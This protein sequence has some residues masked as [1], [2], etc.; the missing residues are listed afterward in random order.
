MYVC[1]SAGKKCSF[2]RKIWHALLSR[3]TRFEIRLFALLPMT[4]YLNST[5]VYFQD[6]IYW[7]FI[8]KHPYQDSLVKLVVDKG[9]NSDFAFLKGRIHCE[10]FLSDNFM[11][12]SFRVI[13]WN[14]KYFH[15]ILLLK[16]PT[17]IAYVQ[18]QPPEV[19][20][21]KRCS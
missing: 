20:C 3:N 19:F 4:Y 13:S 15:G 2:F 1:V 8:W 11:K 18:K 16:Y 6:L 21:K 7:K 14:M 12:Y 5:V 17:F 9:I 10:I